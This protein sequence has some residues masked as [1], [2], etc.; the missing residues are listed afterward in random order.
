MLMYRDVLTTAYS[1][2]TDIAAIYHDPLGGV[3][4]YKNRQEVTEAFIKNYEIAANIQAYYRGQQTQIA[5][6]LNAMKITAKNREGALADLDIESLRGAGEDRLRAMAGDIAAAGKNADGSIN[7]KAVSKIIRG[8]FAENLV[9]AVISFRTNGMLSALTTQ[10][11]NLVSSTMTAALRPAEKFLAGAARYSTAEGRAQMAEAAIQ[12]GT[13]VASVKD[14]ISMAAKAFRLNAPQLDPGRS[15]VMENMSYK[16]P[17]SEAFNIQNS[18]A[19]MVA[20]DRDAHVGRDI[21]KHAE[22]LR[23]MDRRILVAPAGRTGQTVDDNHLDLTFGFVAEPAQHRSNELSSSPICECVPHAHHRDAKAGG[24][25]KRRLEPAAGAI[26]RLPTQDQRMATDRFSSEPSVA[27]LHCDHKI[28]HKRRLAGLWRPGQGRDADRGYHPGDNPLRLQQG[29]VLSD[30]HKTQR[31]L[32]S[33]S[34]RQGFGLRRGGPHAL[35]PDFNSRP[36]AARTAPSNSS[37]S[38]RIN[39]RST[40]TRSSRSRIARISQRSQSSAS[41]A[42][43]WDM[44]RAARST[45]STMRTTGKGIRSAVM[46]RLARIGF[47]SLSA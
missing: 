29:P 36:R 5:R 19:A 15:R 23:H 40:P 39:V 20:D 14:G 33:H 22:S 34:I 37:S 10:T 12:Y 47:R 25:R 13:M 24:G 42:A 2:L 28:S 41:S 35:P 1:K 21:H 46:P 4:P 31:S 38:R 18:T 26:G 44:N 32:R 27:L 11:V 3:G 9:N 30:Q 45:V 8:G 6:S 16:R 17:P 43:R 7:T